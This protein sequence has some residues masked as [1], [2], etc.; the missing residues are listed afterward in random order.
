LLTN[1]L[2]LSG[3]NALLYAA[4]GYAHLQGYHLGTKTDDSV[5]Q[6]IMRYAQRALQLDPNSA[7]AHSVTGST[8]LLRGEPQLAVR[9]LKQALALDA[10]HADALF[11]LS[12]YYSD[13]G[14]IRLAAPLAQRLAELDP[15][16]PISQAMPGWTAL[17]DGRLAEALAP[18]EKL[19][20][21]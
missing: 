5:L 21:M 20:R 4:L 18:Y 17:L 13:A 8:H 14:F 3:P 16:T 6:E 7:H 9:H 10:N 11:Q 19:H 15:L 2:A 12:W 1:G